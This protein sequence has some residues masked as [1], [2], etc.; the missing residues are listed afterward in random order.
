MDPIIQILRDSVNRAVRNSSTETP[1]ESFLKVCATY[2]DEP[3]HSLAELR[4]K[5]TTKAKGDIF[6]NFC[7]LYLKYILEFD[8]VWLLKDIPVEVREML[9]L[10]TKDFGIDLV[11]K[12]NN[13][14]SAVQCKFKTPRKDG[15]VAGADFIRY[16][17]VNWSEISTF[18]ALTGRS[19]PWYKYIVMT[20]AKS[21]AKPPG[22]SKDVDEGISKDWRIC[23]GTFQKLT[24]LDFIKMYSKGEVVIKKETKES[25]KVLDK[26][27]KPLCTVEEV[28]LKR[29]EYL[30]NKTANNGGSS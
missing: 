17:K 15:T 5:R 6:E 18:Y 14:Y 4:E 29:L 2:T 16:N 3:V 24:T 28:R 30:N 10:G 27:L 13:K 11:V 22:I 20:T 23:I 1:F 8:Q 21:V 26:T 12:K 19:G 7:V 25:D 9:S